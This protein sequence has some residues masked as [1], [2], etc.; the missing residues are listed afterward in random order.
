MNTW[1]QKTWA[2]KP[3]KRKT[4]VSSFSLLSNQRD[5]SSFSNPSGNTGTSRFR[6]LGENRQPPRVDTGTQNYLSEEEEVPYESLIKHKKMKTKPTLDKE[7]Q[8]PSAGDSDCDSDEFS[9]SMS[10]IPIGIPSNLVLQD[11]SPRELSPR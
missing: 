7:N 6:G 8:I 2:K 4:V 5:Q 9:P 3:E 1:A 11:K 10:P